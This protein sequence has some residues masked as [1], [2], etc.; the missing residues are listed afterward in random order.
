MLLNV[1]ISPTLGRLLYKIVALQVSTQEVLPRLNYLRTY[2]CSTVIYNYNVAKASKFQATG[3]YGRLVGYEGYAIYQVYILSLYKV[4]RTKD[5]EFFK[6]D[7]PLSL[8]KDKGEDTLYDDVFPIQSTI[9][10]SNTSRGNEARVTFT[11][12]LVII[13]PLLYV[14]DNDVPDPKLVQEI[15]NIVEDGNLEDLLPRIQPETNILTIENYN[16][17]AASV[18]DINTDRPRN[19][20]TR[21]QE[22]SILRRSK[23][24]R[25]QPA[26]IADPTNSYRAN[27]NRAKRR[28]F[29]YDLSKATR[30][31]LNLML[32][33]VISA[34][35]A[36]ID[37]PT[38]EILVPKS[39]KQL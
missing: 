29:Y 26:F 25:R 37:T 34:F 27:F 21:R 3:I 7:S 1:T 32:N 36:A 31:E 22:A 33:T 38:S 35:I 13:L 20:A 39:Y 28:A 19:R 18:L 15:Y 10:E 16:E 4:V 12:E 14:E 6:G 24:L 11:N 9:K 23:R 2:S 5:V 30:R 8:D 17:E